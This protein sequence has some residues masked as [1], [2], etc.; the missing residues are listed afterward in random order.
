MATCGSLPSVGIVG[1]PDQILTIAPI[2]TSEGFPLKAIWCKTPE[3]TQKLADKLSI[4]HFPPTFQA[5]LLLQDVDLVYVATE[6]FLQAEVAVKALTSGKHCISMK[7]PSIC[8][9]EVDKMLSLSQYYSQLSTIL[10]THMR[11]IP[12]FVKLKEF[13]DSGQLGDIF[14]INVQVFTGSLVGNEH[15]S[16]KCD[17][18]LGGGVLNLVGSHIV[19]LVSHLCSK[20]NQVQQVNCLLN[21]FVCHTHC[22]HGYR[23]IEAD[24]Y[25]L[26][27]LK[28]PNSILASVLINANCGSRYRLELTLTGKEG[29]ATVR[30]FDLFWQSPGSGGEEKTIFKEEV[31]SD[32][33][34]QEAAALNLPPKLYQSTVNGYRGLFRKLKEYFLHSEEDEEVCPLATFSDGH[35]LRTVLDCARESHKLGKWITVPST[36]MASNANPFWTTTSGLK[37]DAT[38]KGSGYPVAYV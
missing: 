26:L 4:L 35:H 19:D 15:Y 28:F 23:T 36:S 22:I 2:L 17:H 27:Q 29:T 25:C 10:E 24:D 13:I 37:P 18:S 12:C 5:L 33:V 14:T 7:P 16:W 21:T 1:T 34:S 20:P 8:A 6:P 30:D 31:V 38:E 9:S 3:V 11:F 32:D